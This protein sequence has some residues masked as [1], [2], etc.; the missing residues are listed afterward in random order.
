MTPLQ[1]PDATEE[2]AGLSVEDVRSVW[3]VYDRSQ[4]RF[5]LLVLK[6]GRSIVLPGTEAN[7]VYLDSVG[8][9]PLPLPGVEPA[10]TGPSGPKA[11]G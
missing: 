4:T 1:L 5:L 2:A 7:I 10:A 11:T 6:D 3:L 8:L 9:T